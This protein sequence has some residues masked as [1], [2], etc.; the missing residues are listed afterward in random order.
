MTKT[1][2]ELYNG[3]LVP[4]K[5]LGRFNDEITHLEDLMEKNLEKLERELNK[6]HTEL[7]KKYYGNINEYILLISEEAFCDG[8]SI[9]TKVTAEAICAAEKII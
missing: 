4:I 1:I 5:N 9:G 2:A 6:E 7:F 3:N 8:F